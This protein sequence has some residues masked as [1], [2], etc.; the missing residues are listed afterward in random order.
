MSGE[1]QPAPGRHTDIHHLQLGLAGEKI[2]FKPQYAKT[3]L[4]SLNLFSEE[5][6][7]DRVQTMAKHR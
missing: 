6:F 4:E 1:P 2:S 7:A 5:S 3:T